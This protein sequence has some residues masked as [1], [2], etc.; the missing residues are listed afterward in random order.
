MPERGEIVESLKEALASVEEASIPSDLREAA[1]KAVLGAMGLQPAG[2]GQAPS[3]SGSDATPDVGGGSGSGRLSGISKK[4]G[5]EE[6]G[7]SEVFDVDDE[8]VHLTVRRAVLDSKQKVA[9]QEIAYLVVAARQAGGDEEWTPISF[10]A[11]AA[12]DRGVHDTN[13]ARNVGALDG[14]GIRFKGQRSKRELKMN[15]V[16]FEKAAAVVRRIV[17]SRQ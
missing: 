9:Q 14:E 5:I 3:G 12:H 2:V 17:E 15:Q 4:L 16:G 7:V 13:F 1:F 6:A 11:D 10:V 8:G